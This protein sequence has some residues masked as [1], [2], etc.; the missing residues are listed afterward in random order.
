MG[1]KFRSS[2]RY[3]SAIARVFKAQFDFAESD[4]IAACQFGALDAHTIYKNT[5]GA[6][7]V[8]DDPSI[9]M[10]LEQGMAARDAGM[11]KRNIV[12]SGSAD[13][14]RGTVFQ[15]VKT[16]LCAGPLND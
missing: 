2:F 14:N 3:D 8:F 13:V 7:L 15:F 5:V 9:A 1:S 11:R 4:D 12:R 10:P 6:A 16:R